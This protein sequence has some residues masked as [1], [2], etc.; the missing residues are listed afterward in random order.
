MK[1]VA[2]FPQDPNPYQRLLH[3]ALAGEGVKASYVPWPTGSHTLNLLLLP[4][5][6]GIARLRGARLLHLHWVYPFCIP[7]LSRSVGAR[8]AEVWFS[9]FLRTVRLCRMS[10]VWT[11]HNVL[12]H[13]PVFPDDAAQRR[14]LVAAADAVVVHSEVTARKLA[15]IG[16]RPTRTVTVPHGPYGDVWTE[17]VGR[18]E[19]RTRL[20]VPADASIVLFFG[21]VARYKGVQDL[22]AVWPA[23]REAFPGALLLVVGQCDDAGLRA[24][25]SAAA[26]SANSVDLRPNHVPEP[27]VPS[28]FA[29]ADLVALPFRAVT[30]SGSVTLAYS[31]GRAVLIPDLEELS[32]APSPAALRHAPTLDGL[33]TGLLAALSAGR[34]ELDDIG[35]RGSNALRRDDWKTAAK[36]HAQLYASLD[37]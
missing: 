3:T 36:R 29:A 26:T 30:T 8:L 15:D 21:K 14:R 12:P 13:S 10:L 5:S 7:F 4:V 6:V 33:R 22:V 19:A 18:A 17:T 16:A 1:K 28:Y 34:N 35:A 20:G 27:D 25:L 23:V 32:D 37:T 31:L 9:V 2:V 24:E 11:A